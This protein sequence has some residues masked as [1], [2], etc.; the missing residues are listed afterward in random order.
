MSVPALVLIPGCGRDRHAYD[1]LVACLDGVDVIPLSLPGRD[2]IPGPAPASAREAALWVRARLRETGV[3]RAIIGGHSYGGGVAIELALLCGEDGTGLVAG[4]VLMDTG[5][6]LR[7]HPDILAGAEAAC[8]EEPAND[9][10]AANLADWRACD[11][12]DR[13]PEVHR[14]AVPT[15]VLVGA[16]DVLTP[17]KYARYLGDRV[18]DSQVVVL[19]DAGHDAPSTH[20]REVAAAILEFLRRR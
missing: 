13:L 11:A 18:A 3:S 2:G 20:P 15:L 14:I 7:A 19:P 6:R 16:D 5:A 12:F 10:L 9:L 4:L 8:A 1:P 17:P